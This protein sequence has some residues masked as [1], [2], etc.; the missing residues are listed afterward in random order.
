MDR[1]R[2]LEVN[3]SER[4]MLCSG[5]KRLGASLGQHSYSRAGA[6]FG[7]IL[8]C[9]VCDVVWAGKS[10]G[11]TQGH[12]GD[13]TSLKPGMGLPTSVSRH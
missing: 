13:D 10:Q 9:L 6:S 4:A 11:H 3:I 1:S 7:A 5:G 12:L 8:P 2:T